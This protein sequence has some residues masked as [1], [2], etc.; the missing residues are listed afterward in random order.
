MNCARLFLCSSWY[1]GPEGFEE[2]FLLTPEQKPSRVT[3]FRSASA[4]R[5]QR[6]QCRQVLRHRCARPAMPIQPGLGPPQNPVYPGAELTAALDPAQQPAHPQVHASFPP[7]QVPFDA[8]CPILLSCVCMH[9]HVHSHAFK[10]Q[11]ACIWPVHIPNCPR[12][13]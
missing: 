12:S 6:S 10:P 2:R 13:N 4:R 8:S 3:S 7:M 1:S 11:P 9:I 5:T